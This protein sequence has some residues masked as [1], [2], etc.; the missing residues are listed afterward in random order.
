MAAHAC[1]ESTY[2]ATFLSDM[3]GPV[4]NYQAPARVRKILVCAGA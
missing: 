4:W 2:V 3:D 1:S